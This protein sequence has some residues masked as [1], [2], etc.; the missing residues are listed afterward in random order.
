[1]QPPAW[2][3]SMTHQKARISLRLSSQVHCCLGCHSGRTSHP[4]RLLGCQELLFPWEESGSFWGGEVVKSTSV[5]ACWGYEVS[6]PFREIG[7]YHWVTGRAGSRI[8]ASW[9]L[10]F[11]FSNLRQMWKDSMMILTSA[12]KEIT[13]LND[14]RICRLCPRYPKSILEAWTSKAIKF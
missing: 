6:S 9:I 4:G 3:L 5:W 13:Q 12:G 10:S 8:Q 11:F 2:W 14:Q 7:A 1:M